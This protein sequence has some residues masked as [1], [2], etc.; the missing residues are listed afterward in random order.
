MRNWIA[1][2]GLARGARLPP[3]RELCATLGVSR[4][5]L[6]KALLVLEADGALERHVGRG[7]FLAKAPRPSRGGTGVDATIAALA[8]TTG[9]VEAM[10]ARLALEPE[11]AQRAALHATPKQLRELRRLAD[12]MRE[13][14]SWGAYEQLDSEFHA[15][16]AAASGNSLLQSLH[17][18]LN[19]VRQ[20]V[21]WRRLNTTDRGPDPAYHSFNEHDAIFAALENRD[22]TAA[23]AAMR[24]HLDST[25]S[26]MTT[27][28]SD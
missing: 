8:E 3:E 25:L 14:T 7:T 15:T 1:T 24:A 21:V 26:L 2:A 22:G 11:I 13:A 23:G 20:A 28:P 6:R 12:A 19:G 16:I 5:E 27:S 4:A 10:N 17:R 9:P 18:I